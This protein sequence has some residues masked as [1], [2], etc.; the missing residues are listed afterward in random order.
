MIKPPLATTISSLLVSSM[1]LTPVVTFAAGGYRGSVQGVATKEQA[2]RADYESR[3]RQAIAAGDA[4]MKDKD[5]EKATAYYKNACDIIPNAP[6]SQSLYNVALRGFCDASCKLAEQR[7]TE[8]RYAEAEATLRIVIDERYDPG[9]HHA[10]V[11]L[12]RLEQP[13]YYNK[14]IGP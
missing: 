5:Y 3:G 12:S 9:C 4:A 7:I 13:D 14:T 6:N 1:I 8:G 10:H 2:R 11:I